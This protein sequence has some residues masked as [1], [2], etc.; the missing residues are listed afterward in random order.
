MVKLFHCF[1]RLETLTTLSTRFSWS[2]L[3]KML[4]APRTL[5]TG[6]QR[7][8]GCKGGVR[9]ASQ[10]DLLDRIGPEG[11]QCATRPTKQLR[12]EAGKLGGLLA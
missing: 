3:V 1:D 8:D 11:H 10:L 5:A 2:H 9:S 12:S 6:L 4:T 7:A